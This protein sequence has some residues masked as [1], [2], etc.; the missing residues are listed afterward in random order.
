MN[1]KNWT[2]LLREPRDGP[3]ESDMDSSDLI[4]AVRNCQD[5][6]PTASVP[7][8][9]VDVYEP[10][11]TAG[12]AG[13]A[14]LVG[15][16]GADP[17]DGPSA[18]PAGI[19]VESAC[20]EGG[21]CCYRRTE[22]VPASEAGCRIL[23]LDQWQPL[24]ETGGAG[25]C[26]QPRCVGD[27]CSWRRFRVCSSTPIPEKD[28]SPVEIWIHASALNNQMGKKVVKVGNFCYESVLPR[29]V[30]TPPNG[31]HRVGKGSFSLVTACDD[32]RCLCCSGVSEVMELVARGIKERVLWK[33][34]G[35]LPVVSGHDFNQSDYIL[36]NPPAGA[37][38][39]CHL[40]AAA[41]RLYL[42]ELD[43][44]LWDSS[45]LYHSNAWLKKAA[46]FDGETAE[47][48][49]SAG[50]YNDMI[51]ADKSV[52]WFRS[53]FGTNGTG[54]TFTMGGE[55]GFGI[56]D[57]IRF[58]DADPHVIVLRAENLTPWC[59]LVNETA[60]RMLRAVQKLEGV[61]Q[62][63]T[64]EN[65]SWTEAIVSSLPG[66]CSK[67]QKLITDEWPSVTWYD[68]DERNIAIYDWSLGSADSDPSSDVSVAAYVVK[69]VAKVDLTGFTSGNADIYFRIGIPHPPF[70]S[71]VA[72]QNPP[73]A[74]DS[75]YRR[76]D[77]QAVAGVYALP[78]LQGGHAPAWTRSCPSAPP[79]G[80]GWELG[81]ILAVILG[82]FIV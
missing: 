14:N 49:Y 47:E 40:R 45:W 46:S 59:N 66:P 11:G 1:R 60:K 8:G 16:V 9:W 58:G 27:S 69:G 80:S 22:T 65:R 4:Q 53:A 5:C 25:P 34:G 28:S 57:P 73:V 70:G 38:V 17:E 3:A 23:G 31:A 18:N 19:F 52:T 2:R 13:T 41:W 43:W 36:N 50:D 78:L 76:I 24:E 37:S 26:E 51:T 67:W 55:G 35:T 33:N 74:A 6:Q 10:C 64:Q 48:Y 81:N 42:V 12:C 54:D 82:N 44:W 20:A 63:G 77:S 75:K 56:T 15:L 7:G 71:L 30:K 68:T 61:T 29:C 32:N 72:G 79:N 39:P 21:G 62:A